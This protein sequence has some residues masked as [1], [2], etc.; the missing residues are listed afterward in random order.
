M[1]ARRLLERRAHGGEILRVD[2]TNV[3]DAERFAQLD[4][5]ERLARGDIE[6]VD[7]FGLLHERDTV[8]GVALA[9]GHGRRAVVEDAQRA[10]AGVVDRSEQAGDARVGEGAVADDADDG[11]LVSLGNAGELEAMC[12]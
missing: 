8:A 12:H 3:L 4:D 1:R 5:I 10:R 7:A 11:A 6:R 2:E 9:A